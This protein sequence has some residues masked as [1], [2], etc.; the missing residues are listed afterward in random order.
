MSSKWCAWVLQDQTDVFIQQLLGGFI[1]CTSDDKRTRRRVGVQ[2]VGGVGGQ[3]D[4]RGQTLG[5][6]AADVPGLVRLFFKKEK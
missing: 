2:G 1:H 4:G 5:G 6:R 3:G